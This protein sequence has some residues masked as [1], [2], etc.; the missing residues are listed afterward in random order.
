VYLG[1]KRRY[2]NTL[3]FLFLLLHGPGCDGRG[4]PLVVH[5]GADLQS[6]HGFRWYD[7]IA[8]NAKCQ[9]ELV[10][11]LCMFRNSDIASL[12]KTALF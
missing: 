5:Y 11:V 12:R 8:P 1:A 3:P 4:Y 10:L 9:R 2:I 6:V 7:N